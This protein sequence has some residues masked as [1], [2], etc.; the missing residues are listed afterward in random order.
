[1]PSLGYGG[2]ESQGE[3]F[4]KPFSEATAQALDQAVK[5]MVTDAHTKT[6]ALLT[7]KKADVEKV[8]QLLLKKEVITRED[9]RNRES[10]PRECSSDAWLME[11]P[12]LA[13]SFPRLVLGRR[14]FAAADEMDRYIEGK[15]DDL[16]GKKPSTEGST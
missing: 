15:L 6:K 13:L 5:K 14:P 10:S 2:R 4:Q 1:V 16:K 12:R 11:I 3:Q 7:E 8:A 9:M